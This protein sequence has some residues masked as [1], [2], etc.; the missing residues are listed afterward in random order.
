MS[1]K[2]MSIR[3]KNRKLLIEKEIQTDY[4]VLKHLKIN[5]LD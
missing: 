1:E 3:F 4:N 5:I 2:S